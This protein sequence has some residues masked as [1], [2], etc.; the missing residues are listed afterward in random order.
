MDIE[1]DMERLRLRLLRLVAGWL[2]AVAFLSAAP[3]SCAVTRWVGEFL[4]SVL[5]KAEAAAQSLVF[6]Q[7][8]LL[9][10]RSGGRVDSACLRDFRLRDTGKDEPDLALATLRKRLDALRALLEDLPRSGAR[11]LRRAEKRARRLLGTERERPALPSPAT[12]DGAALC[13]WR[14]ATLRIERPPDKRATLSCST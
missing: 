11:L 6:V 4:F 7:A 14:L 3:F 12:L 2:V 1:R 10:A 8:R 9:A 13:I 5:S